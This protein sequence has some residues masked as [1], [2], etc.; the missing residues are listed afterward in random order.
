VFAR[1]QD[2]VVEAELCH[3][4]LLHGA[5]WH[6][7]TGAVPNFNLRFDHFESRLRDIPS[8]QSPDLDFEWLLIIPNMGFFLP[9]LHLRLEI[10]TVHTKLDMAGFGQCL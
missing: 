9:C 7:G 2:R 1:V 10:G 5:C 3:H 6:P 8:R 4:Q